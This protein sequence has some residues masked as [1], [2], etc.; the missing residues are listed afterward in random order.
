MV[1][2][3]KLSRKLGFGENLSKSQIPETSNK[4]KNK[5]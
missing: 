3:V 1:N 4:I 5:F 2:F